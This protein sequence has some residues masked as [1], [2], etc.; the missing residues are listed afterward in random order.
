LITSIQGSLAVSPPKRI[1]G[2]LVV[3]LMAAGSGLLEAAPFPEQEPKVRATLKG[4]AGSVAFVAFSPDGKT[5]ASASEE[6]DIRLWDTT[7]GTL[8]GN[9]RGRGYSAYAATFSPDGRRG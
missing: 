6:T 9:L 1:A 5:V 8:T 7:S 3:V 2:Y 4:H